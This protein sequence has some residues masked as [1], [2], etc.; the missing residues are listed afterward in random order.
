MRYLLDTNVVSQLVR[1]EPMICRR[2]QQVIAE[3][4]C[5]S[6]I[7]EAEILAGLAKKPQA[8][9]LATTM[10]SFLSSAEVLSWDSQAAKRYAD[11]QVFFAKHGK[12]LSTMNALIAAHAHAAGATLVTADKAFLQLSDF[13]P[14][15]DWT[16]PL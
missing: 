6:V 13:V 4:I 5:V 16:I 9:K 2:L 11:L 12:A 7:T 10:H 15:E 14:V 3:D 8:I 1:K